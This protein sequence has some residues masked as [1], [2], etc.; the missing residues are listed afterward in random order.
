ML[1]DVPKVLQISATKMG[2][3]QSVP[4]CTASALIVPPSGPS[5]S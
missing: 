5:L 4:D 3:G 2:F 1:E